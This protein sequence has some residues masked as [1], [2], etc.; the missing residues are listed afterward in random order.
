MPLVV[1]LCFARPAL[2]AGVQPYSVI[3][4]VDDVEVASKEDIARIVAPVAV[5]GEVEFSFQ[6]RRGRR[7]RPLLARDRT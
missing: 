1:V 5:G 4:S 2:P 7:S 3:T 6:V